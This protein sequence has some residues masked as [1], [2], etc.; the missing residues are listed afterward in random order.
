MFFY[1]KQEK[2]DVS[3][4]DII[5]KNWSNDLSYFENICLTYEILV[6]NHQSFAISNS[7]FLEQKSGCVDTFKGVI[8]FL[9]LPLVARRLWNW[10]WLQMQEEDNS[11]STEMAISAARTFA[12]AI[13]IARV[14]LGFLLT[15]LL[16]PVVGVMHLTNLFINSLAP[17]ESVSKIELSTS[18]I[19]TSEDEQAEESS[20]IGNSIP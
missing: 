15:V 8:D 4:N 10:S 6:G 3:F 17:C 16:I 9:V 1:N 18:L 7:N 11:F 2:I 19:L 14:L 20:P 5:Q 12:S 13:T